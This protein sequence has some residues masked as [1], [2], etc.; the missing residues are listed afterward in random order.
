M[1]PWVPTVLEERLPLLRAEADELERLPLLPLRELIAELLRLLVRVSTDEPRLLLALRELTDEFLVAPP[2]LL[3]PTVEEL[4]ELIDEPL[5]G[6]A[7]E[8]RVPD[9]AERLLTDE[10]LRV[11]PLTTFPLVR[12]ELRTLLEAPPPD[13]RK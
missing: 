4:R 10:P 1:P 13:D 7:D 6:I 11:L 5:R 3:V 8:L 9:E 2:P 12:L